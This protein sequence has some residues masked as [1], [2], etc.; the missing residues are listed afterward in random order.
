VIAAESGYEREIESDLIAGE[1]LVNVHPL[2]IKRAV[3]NMVVNAARY[4]NGWIKVSSGKE[5]QRGWFQVED[6]GPGIEQSQLK[7]LFQPFVRGDSARTTSGT[8]L[9]LA[10]VQRIIDAH[11]GSLDIGRSPRGGLRIRAYLPLPVEKVVTAALPQ[12]T[13]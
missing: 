3:A 7:H 12:K 4:G 11:A 5:L 13:V 1:V 2:S 8:G 10:I 6:D 9:G